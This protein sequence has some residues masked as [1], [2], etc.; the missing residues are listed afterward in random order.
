MLRRKNAR[1]GVALGPASSDH[2]RVADVPGHDASR[3]SA[4]GRLALAVL[5]ALPFFASASTLILTTAFL[6]EFVGRE[7]LA[8]T[9]D[10]HA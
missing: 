2:W 3:V 5:L 6:A 8:A 7:A 1:H 9:L 4:A 10:A